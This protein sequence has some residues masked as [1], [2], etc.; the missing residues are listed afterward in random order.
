M[1]INQII[2]VACMLCWIYGG[3]LHHHPVIC[4][5]IAICVHVSVNHGHNNLKRIF[6]LHERFDFIRNHMRFMLMHAIVGQSIQF[7]R[8]SRI[9][10]ISITVGYCLFNYSIQPSCNPFIICYIMVNI[11]EFLLWWIFFSICF[12]LRNKIMILYRLPSN[13]SLLSV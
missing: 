4:S 6:I 8:E 5:L 9:I 11:N 7:L 2:A 10:T 12:L 3:V 1:V 13:R